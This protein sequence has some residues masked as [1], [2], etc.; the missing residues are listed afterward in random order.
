MANKKLWSQEYVAPK[1]WSQKMWSPKT[2]LSKKHVVSKTC[3]LKKKRGLK[4]V[5]SKKHGFKIGGLKKHVVK[6]MWSK[7]CICKKTRGLKNVPQKHVVSNKRGFKNMY[8]PP[9][10]WSWSQNMWSQKT[11]SRKKHVVSKKKVISKTCS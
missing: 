8:S 6:N 5:V 7:T 4:N 2:R 1:M 11:W 10:N 9:K 3:D